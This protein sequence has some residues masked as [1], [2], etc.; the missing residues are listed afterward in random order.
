MNG[1]DRVSVKIYEGDKV[2]TVLKELLKGRVL[3]I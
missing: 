2:K 1:R 3:G